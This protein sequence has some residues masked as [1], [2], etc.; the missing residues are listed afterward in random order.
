MRFS[1][2]VK[3]GPCIQQDLCCGLSP[4][5]FSG[6]RRPGCGSR[7]SFLWDSSLER[8]SEATV[9]C[10]HSSQAG[11]KLCPCHILSIEGVS[12]GGH[13]CPQP[14]QR[15]PPPSPRLSGRMETPAPSAL[16]LPQEGHQRGLC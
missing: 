11:G 13:H 14:W 16:A 10:K 15:W 2:E 9:L 7:V 5:R 6:E 12:P 1:G 4:A 3:P 8:D